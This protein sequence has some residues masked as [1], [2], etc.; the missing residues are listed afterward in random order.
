[1]EHAEVYTLEAANVPP[2]S[3]PQSPKCSETGKSL[4]PT[5]PITP[6][7]PIQ[8]S[9]NDTLTSVSYTKSRYSNAYLETL[10]ENSKDD[11][12]VS[13]MESICFDQSFDSRLSDK[14]KRKRKYSP[15]QS[16]FFVK[17]KR[18]KSYSEKKKKVSDFFKT[19]ISYFSNRRR[20]IDASTFS[21]SLNE[22]VISSSGI[23]NV[24][25]VQNLSSC[26]DNTPRTSQKCKRRNLFRRTFSASKFTRSKSRKS[27]NFNATK[28]SFCESSDVDGGEK[29]NAS[30]FPD[31]SLQPLPNTI[32]HEL[33]SH[34]ANTPRRTSV[35]AVL[36]SFHSCLLSSH[37]LYNFSG[38]A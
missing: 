4:S 26:N 12:N 32:I 25:T 35:P 10:H 30:C 11:V 22:S 31:I 14:S 20:T 28:S 5:K 7:T 33:S 2:S 21:Q 19:P 27:I 13:D 18:D 16:S 9:I 38:Y 6:R 3:R 8:N 37:A 23:F 24:E 34:I 17:R 29:L 1:M 15:E 36:T